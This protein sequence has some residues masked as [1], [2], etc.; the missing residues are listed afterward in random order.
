MFRVYPIELPATTY[1]FTGRVVDVV[2][3]FDVPEVVGASGGL[4]IKPEGIVYSPRTARLFELFI[5]G[6]SPTC[7]PTGISVEALSKAYPIGSKVRVIATKLNQFGGIHNGNTVLSTSAEDDI[8]LND[9]RARSSSSLRSVF[10]YRKHHDIIKRIAIKDERYKSFSLYLQQSH[11][12]YWKDLVRLQR[13]KSRMHKIEILERLVYSP[14][15]F[16][17][18]GYQ[19]LLRKYVRRRAV[20]EQMSERRTRWIQQLSY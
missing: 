14:L 8:S 19:R 13:A 7:R 9:S 15:I 20:I 18:R 6:T 10:D 17:Y 3:S 16:D 11:F 2:G 4:V 5:F 12:E 1:V